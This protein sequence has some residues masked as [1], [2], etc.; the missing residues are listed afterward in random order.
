M[1]AGERISRPVSKRH[2]IVY[3]YAA[4]GVRKSP[5][6][7][8]SIMSDIAYSCAACFSKHSHWL[9]ANC[10]QRSSLASQIGGAGRGMRVARFASTTFRVR[11]FCATQFEKTLEGADRQ[12]LHDRKSSAFKP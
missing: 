4:C 12:R 3:N 9:S 5:Y 8:R 11:R 6:F 1:G 7:Q 10:M 2:A